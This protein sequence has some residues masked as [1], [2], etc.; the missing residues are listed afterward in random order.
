[1]EI[2]NKCPT[3]PLKNVMRKCINDAAQENLKS[4]ISTAKESAPS[5][6]D[7]LGGT[8]GTIIFGLIARHF[9]IKFF[10]MPLVFNIL[11]II[12]MIGGV[13]VWVEESGERKAKKHAIRKIEQINKMGYCIRM[14]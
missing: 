10:S 11:F 4:T 1:L 7:T 2:P 5:V 14:D 12:L 13:M 3:E 6:G 8:I 9:L